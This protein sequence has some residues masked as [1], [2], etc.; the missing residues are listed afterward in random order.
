MTR[1][2]LL[3]PC[4]RRPIWPRCSPFATAN[5]RFHLP[6]DPA[7]M[8]LLVPPDVACVAEVA[9]EPP[10]AGEGVFPAPV[11]RLVAAA[12]A[13]MRLH[14]DSTG[15]SHAPCPRTRNFPDG[16]RRAARARSASRCRFRPG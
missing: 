5:D 13:L 11:M 6:A 16:S 12:H 7:I 14:G 4:I 8:L 2:I 3:V 1:E 9:V 10:G 15:G